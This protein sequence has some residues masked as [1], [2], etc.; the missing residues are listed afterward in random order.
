MFRGHG[1]YSLKELQVYRPIKCG[2]RSLSPQATVQSQ[3]SS[4]AGQGS[5][6]LLDDSMTSTPASAEC[7]LAAAAAV[8]AATTGRNDAAGRWQVAKAGGF[9]I[10]RPFTTCD[11]E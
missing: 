2:C 8:A 3:V 5:S 10:F 6:P 1:R 4:A 7:I 9:S 11:L